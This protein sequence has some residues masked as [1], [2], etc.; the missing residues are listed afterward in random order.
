MKHNIIT[1]L[2]LLFS[3]SLIVSSC[4]K[5]KDPVPI[6]PVD[7]VDKVYEGSLINPSTQ[8]MENFLDEGYVIIN[9]DLEFSEVETL[10][11]LYPFANVKSITGS[12]KLIGNPEF[13][14]FEG[15]EN[16]EAIGG[17]LVYDANY[18]DDKLLSIDALYK[19]KT[20]E[21]DF[22]L[23]N[24]TALKDL[25]SLNGLISIGGNFEIINLP[26]LLNFTPLFDL[27][28]IEGDL[29]IHNLI[30][31]EYF[32]GLSG[33]KNI[34]GDLS[35]INNNPSI[36]SKITSTGGLG[37]IERIEGNLTIRNL[38]N[39][40][41]YCALTYLLST[42]G[43][44]GN[45]LV[46]G[47]LYNPS[48]E[49]IINGEC[50]NT[51]TVDLPDGV[52]IYGNGTTL[53]S[54]DEK[55]IMDLAKNEATQEIRPTL[56]EK[57]LTVKGGNEGFQIIS[58]ND[59]VKTY[60]SP[61]SNF[62]KVMENDLN[63]EEPKEGLYRGN[64]EANI[65]QWVDPFIVEEDGLYHIAYD[66]EINIV[67]IAKVEWGIIGA[68]T[69]E[70]WNTSTNLT[71]TFDLFE[72]QYTFTNLAL[73]KGDFKIR[74]SNGWKVI[75]DPD[76]DLGN[77]NMGIKVNSN[78]G[79]T[80]S[81]LIPGGNNIT[82]DVP[83]YYSININWT[84]ENGI[85]AVLIKTG[86][87]EYFD[88]SS[89]ELGLIGSGII[90]NG[91]PLGWENSMLLHTPMISDET[92]YT[93]TYEDIEVST[94]GAFKIREG[95][96]WDGISI[97]Y[98]D[99]SLT[100]QAMNDFEADGDGNFVPLNNGI[101]DFELI[102]NAITEDYTLN[103]HPANGPEPELYLLGDG[104]DAGWDNLAALPFSGT[105]GEYSITAELTG[106]S[107]VIKFITTLGQWAPMYGTDDNGTAQ[108]GNLV[109]RETESDP[110]PASIP[111]DNDGS[112]I[113]TVNT[114]AMTYNVVP[115]K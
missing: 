113:I 98:N 17:D 24:S 74:Y 42:N 32:Y 84:I 96:N 68:A 78:L 8:E 53:L 11:Y 45:Y 4:G 34:G 46:E 86:D 57:Y 39:L 23:K 12:L 19:L 85:G 83:G 16:L 56:Y 111:V 66:S 55:G 62:A 7:P 31:L 70:G 40:K 91:N 48:R 92:T 87:L 102:I 115:A 67:T 36:E 47:N 2:F 15:M 75:L 30:N 109:F 80:I 43:L 81:D 61:S 33:L 89:T 44:I 38:S 60:L 27:K 94:D 29:I 51:N 64:I 3:I 88:Y 104:C 50:Q 101:Y 99:V 13:R 105:N 65:D 22:I 63:P 20:I 112:Y 6:N 21:G 97:T 93:W 106:N 71:E 1:K 25:A 18:I 90:Q 72:P 76:Y 14:S 58:V 54:L 35:I 73:T 10:G 95:E 69:P 5:D 110:D 77:G 100:G 28:T 9:G 79:N 41:H 107:H 26:N 103:V 108:S 49:Q 114:N 59:H 52:Y 82:N 37:S